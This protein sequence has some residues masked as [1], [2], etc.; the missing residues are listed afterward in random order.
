MNSRAAYMLLGA[1]WCVAPVGAAHNIQT[2]IQADG[3]ILLTNVKPKKKLCADL[4]VYVYR[5][6]NGNGEH[7][8]DK[9]LTNSELKAQNLAFVR[10]IPMQGRP[11]AKASCLKMTD[12][13]FKARLAQY[14]TFIDK[15]AGSY[16]LD[17]NLV[18][19]VIHAES[20]F[21]KRAVSKVGARGL[22][23]LMPSTAEQLGVTDSFDAEQN[24]RGGSKYLSQLKQEFNHDLKLALAAYNAGPANVRKY[25]GI[26]PFAETQN[27]VAKVLD[28]YQ[29]YQAGAG[30]F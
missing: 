2:I 14:V 10:A 6:Q 27:Y 24:I 26:P 5:Y 19:A 3:S 13:K 1:L 15:Y 7:W 20:C 8:T 4:C 30:H 25:N 22:M 21:D 16:A 28:F 11:P 12:A 29:K 17:S 23:Q 18:K 9:K